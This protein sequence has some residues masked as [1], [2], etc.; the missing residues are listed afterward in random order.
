MPDIPTFRPDAIRLDGRVFAFAMAVSVLASVVFGLVPA[1][2]A[3]HLDADASLREGSRGTR[4]T[5]RDRRLRNA[6]V[7]S[8][9]ALAMI[10]LAGAGLLLDGLLRMQSDRLGFS[11]DH[12]LT[13]GLCC[14]D[15]RYPT[16]SDATAYY[17]HVFERLRALPGLEAATAIDVL[18]LRQLTT[19]GSAVAVDGLPL[20]P[21][22]APTADAFSVEPSYFSAMQVPL[23]R[24]R[25]FE[26]RDDD[27]GEPVALVNQL[28]AR[29][30]WAGRDP[31]GG[32]I[33]AE[34]DESARWRRVVGVVADTKQRGL[35]TEERPTVYLSYYQDRQDH[36]FFLLRTHS[37]P[38]SMADAARRAIASVDPEIPVDVARTLDQAM[39]ESLSTQRF[40]TLL[41]G[42][43][44]ALAVSLAVAGVYGVTSYSVAQRAQ[45]MGVR[46][47]LGA[48]PTDV[49]KLVL[50]ESL[51]LSTIGI[52]AGAVG[53][54][55]LTRLLGS[56]LLGAGHAN[57]LVFA[58]VGLLLGSVAFLA[59]YIPA[60]RATA[61]DP[62]AALRAE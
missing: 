28:L 37:D 49:L 60:R 10:V 39:W 33:R 61:A 34:A 57:P 42:L 24:G 12:V 26:D 51:R 38:L 23:L 21:R 53:A 16:A 55:E 59:C 27:T 62:M 31:I 17:R 56:L 2:T 52:V 47:A 25:A 40:S 1:L 8:E 29:R 19:A 6:L 11:H 5:P 18:P 14:L 15:H 41:L 58:S 36:A 32:H 13:V 4:H 3:S 22:H 50:R 43:F 48:G 35:G 9:M 46:M 30:L 45:E 44:A 7:A 54:L 20:E